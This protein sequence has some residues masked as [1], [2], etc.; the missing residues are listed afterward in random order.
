MGI[1][2]FMSVEPKEFQIGEKQIVMQR[3]VFGFSRAV[4][5][6]QI[7]NGTF[8]IFALTP[9]EMRARFEIIFESKD[10]PW[11]EDISTDTAVDIVA[12]I[13][14]INDFEAF[15]KKF[16]AAM[17]HAKIVRSGSALPQGNDKQ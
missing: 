8:N 12:Y 15:G 7:G 11:Y 2:E 4:K 5:Y 9:E 17:E 6:L 10:L 14:T 3:P 1:Q 13:H 16:M